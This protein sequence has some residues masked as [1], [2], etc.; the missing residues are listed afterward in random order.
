[1]NFTPSH[2]SRSVL[3]TS[4]NPLFGVAATVL[5]LAGCGGASD[6][7]DRL[8]A[9]DIKRAF[10]RGIPFIGNP[11]VVGHPGGISIWPTYNRRAVVSTD[12]A[13]MQL[14]FTSTDASGSGAF[15][16]DVEPGEPTLGDRNHRRVV[17]I[18]GERSD[19]ALRVTEANGMAMIGD[20]ASLQ[21]DRRS[22]SPIGEWRNDSW[23][24]RLVSE[25][26]LDRPDLLRLC[27]VVR[28]PYNDPAAASADPARGE[29]ERR[30]CS[31]HQRADGIDVG[32]LVVDRTSTSET[33]YTGHW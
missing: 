5:V 17:D 28:L 24:V 25:S 7:G 33:T 4:R 6:D 16:I 8:A 9:V 2:R 21:V 1:M 31:E 14:F 3:K 19:T 22:G 15:R 23:W 20:N 27:W 11:P 18:R 12:G 30:Q 26:V 32:A 29:I 10:D 13:Q